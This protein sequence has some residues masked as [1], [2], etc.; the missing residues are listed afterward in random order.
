MFIYLCMNVSVYLFSIYIEKLKCD[1]T[2]LG[3][4]LEVLEAALKIQYEHLGKSIV[5]NKPLRYSD[6]DATAIRKHCYSLD[7]LTSID[8]FSIL[9]NAMNNYHL[10]P[11]ESLLIFKLKPSLNAA[12]KRVNS[13]IFV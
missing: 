1:R 8:N 4:S 2:T 7:H 3:L 5:T 9:G 11:K 10:S 13:I 12:S 6:K